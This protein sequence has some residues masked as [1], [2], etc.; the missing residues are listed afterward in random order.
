MAKANFEQ[1]VRLCASP[2]EGADDEILDIQK[3]STH[4][5]SHELVRQ[6]TSPNTLVRE[7]VC[8]CVIIILYLDIIHVFIVLFLLHDNK[9]NKQDEKQHSRVTIKHFFYLGI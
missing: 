9:N 2:I 6:V 8:Y 4:D 5:V 3:K 7:Q 1:M